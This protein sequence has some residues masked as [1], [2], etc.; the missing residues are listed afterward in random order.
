MKKKLFAIISLFAA[1]LCSLFLFACGE[2]PTHPH[3]FDKQ[4]A[5]QKYLASEATCTEKAKYYYSCKC[6]EKGTETF[7]YGD[8]LGHDYSDYLCTRCYAID[9]TAPDTEGLKYDPNRDGTYAVYGKGTATGNYIKIPSTYN[10]KAVTTIRDMAFSG[11]NELKSITIPDSVTSIG[12]R[13][14]DNC[15]GLAS[16]CYTGDIAGW[17][18]ITFGDVMS[19]PTVYVDNLYINNALIAGE[20]TIPDNVKEIKAYAFN[21][22]DKLTSVTIPN[23]VTSIGYRAFYVCEGL[24]SVSIPDSITSIGESAFDGC[25]SLKYN[26]YENALYLGND[27]NPYVVLIKAKEFDIITSCTIH[28]DTKLINTGA[29][30][31]CYGL[32]SVTIPDGVTSIG[33]GAFKSC[34]KLTSIKIPDGVTSIGDEAFKSCGKL[35]SIKIPD[36]VTSIGDGAFN[37]CSKLTSIKIPDSVTSIGDDAFTGCPLNCNE[38]ENALYLG[39]DDNPYVVLIKAKQTDIT[40]CT[41]HNDTKIIYNRAFYSC[42]KLTGIAIPDS[43]ISIGDQAFNGCSSLTSITIP[44]CVTSIG[45]NVFDF[46]SALKSVTFNNTSGWFVANSSTDTS[47]TNISSDDLADAATAASYL[48]SEYEN[49]YWKCVA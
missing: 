6:G 30:K 32:T 29:F 35:T 26:E 19:N 7:E 14:F 48:T 36:G 15:D 28:D 31:N 25:Y 45:V 18:E 9:P 10:G 20:L 17:C 23:S 41:I 12:G 11:R 16:V 40:S 2:E 34:G 33:D 24:T 8:A 39:D 21:N 49:Y 44:D 37:E 27:A 38:Y 42:E 22:Y 13:A 3:T 43:V 46:C 4:V 5:E 1:A 47:G